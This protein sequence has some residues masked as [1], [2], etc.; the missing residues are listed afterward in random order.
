MAHILFMYKMKNIDSKTLP[1][2]TPHTKFVFPPE[3]PF[4]FTICKMVTS[5]INGLQLKI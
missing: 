3:V 1:R 5:T 2:E 4:I